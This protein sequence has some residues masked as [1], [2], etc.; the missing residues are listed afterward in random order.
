[1]I[2]NRLYFIYVILERNSYLIPNIKWSIISEATARH[3]SYGSMQVEP[4]EPIVVHTG[5]LVSQASSQLSFDKV[6]NIYKVC[7][8]KSSFRIEAKSKSKH[9]NSK[10]L[11]IVN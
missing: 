3:R 11:D 7:L 2:G 1:M 9:P 4:S 10:P 6:G 8:L 5:I